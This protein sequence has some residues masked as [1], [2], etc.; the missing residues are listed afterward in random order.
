[1]CA[2]KVAYL[3]SHSPSSQSLVSADP[4]G[5]AGDGKT[6]GSPISALIEMNGCQI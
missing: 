5:D 4:G 1:M 6:G 2:E 3:V